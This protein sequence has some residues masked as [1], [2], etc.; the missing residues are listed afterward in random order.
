MNR[1]LFNEN[2]NFSLGAESYAGL[3]LS[4]FR[5][6]KPETVQL[7]H[8]FVIKKDVSPS[9]AAG[10]ASGFYEG[11]I[12]YYGKILCMPEELPGAVILEFD[13]VYRNCEIKIN[14]MP[15][16]EHKYGYTPFEVNITNYL[17]P[18]ENEISVMVDTLPD[19]NSRW[20]TGGGIYRDVHLL[21]GAVRHIA[22]GGIWVYTADVA[23]NCA[24]LQVEITLEG[25][26]RKESREEIR[27]TLYDP[28]G[29][30]AVSK[31]CRAQIQ[32]PNVVRTVLSVEDAKLWSTE[33]PD[34]Y[35]LKAELLTDQNVT[36]T[37]EEYLGIRTLSL[38]HK[39]GLCVNGES[40]KLHGGCV[41]HDNGVIGA[42]S[43]YAAEERRV[44]KL[45]EAGYNAI[46]TA[47]NPPSLALLEA[48]DRLGMLVLDEAFDMW[49]TAKGIY[50]YHRD[51]RTHGKEDVQAMVARDRNHPSVILWS[52]G[53]EIED[54]GNPH[55]LEMMKKLI[56]AVREM[57]PTRPA[58]VAGITLEKW[59]SG[60][61]EAAVQKYGEKDGTV[62]LM[63]R[64]IEDI[65][66][67]GADS[68]ITKEVAAYTGILD[69]H[70]SY[71]RYDSLMK[72]YPETVIMGTESYA[73][74]SD[75]VKEVMDQHPQVVGDFVW[76]C[77]DHI[78]EAGLG[79]SVHV[80]VEDE[81]KYNHI[82]GMMELMVKTEYPYRT[83]NCGDFDLNGTLT[84]Q[85]F[86][87]KV[88]WG[89]ENTYLAV[90]PPELHDL[91]E[92][93]VLGFSWP[94]ESDNWNFTGF[95]GKPVKVSVYSGADEVE[96]YLN[97]KRLGRKMAGKT[98][99][100]RAVFDISYQPGILTAVSL[101][102]GERISERTIET[103]GEPVKI[104]AFPEISEASVGVNSLIYVPVEILDHAGR[105]VFD[106]K[107]RV[108]AEV[109]GEGTLLGFG[110][111]APVTD[112]NYAA[113]SFTSFE[114]RL[115]AV[116]RSTGKPGDAV[117][118][119]SA[120]GLPEEKVTLKF[121]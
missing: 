99:R 37:A 19:P 57:D 69:T 48:C 35:K 112:E 71:F 15:A 70:Y 60:E 14:G 52:V 72:R 96:L 77:W 53:N 89:D 114:G 44:R 107:I 43:V 33:T 68:L 25:K 23:D 102:G 45:K 24:A 63:S 76:T 106:A 103:T 83:S 59:D 58:L 116:V 65:F 78:G 108:S 2:W 18:G 95:E 34:R 66:P 91:A 55:G 50:D 16:G 86:F 42:V 92:I 121:K 80:P 119:L 51:F 98:A 29:N 22:P 56:D 94:E 32:N 111:A 49:M 6:A 4:G 11:D 104:K 101:R 87:R 85:G 28:S 117:L 118:R 62:S 100:Y 7:P 82:F 47:H 110:S 90:Q 40:V 84:P 21:T 38:D 9:A 115:L 27:L 39:K 67:S 88:V 1:E 13:G 46:R 61:L 20:Y 17:K 73:A 30:E 109:S 79:R 10:R 8:D 93:G 3:C 74:T 75:L 31:V 54:M 81:A 5:D 26:A 120:E 113:G 105:R 97:G 41:H 36:D 64:D 12:G